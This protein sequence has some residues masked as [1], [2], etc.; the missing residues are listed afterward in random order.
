MN[1]STA[2]L[3]VDE[4]LRSKRSRAGAPKA[5]LAPVR[6]NTQPLNTENATEHSM[7]WE[8]DGGPAADAE[9]P[10]SAPVTPAESGSQEEKDASIRIAQ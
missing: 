10:G 7:R 1:T 5:A 6:T 9:T 8:D 3:R 2:V 4:E